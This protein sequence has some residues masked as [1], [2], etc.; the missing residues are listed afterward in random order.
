MN[1]GIDTRFRSKVTKKFLTRPEGP[2]GAIG[3][4]DV[5]RNV[6][7]LPIQMRAQFFHDATLGRS[8]FTMP[9]CDHKSACVLARDV[10]A[11]PSFGVESMHSS[12]QVAGLRVRR[13]R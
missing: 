5:I 2:R 9:C 13:S 10:V 3:S 6:A 12:K 4:Q 1:P 8:F 11:V 7:R